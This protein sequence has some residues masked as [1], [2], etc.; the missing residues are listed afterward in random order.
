MR[1]FF[2]NII[3]G[4]LTF[5]LAILLIPGVKI[6]DGLKEKIKVILSAGIVLGLINQFIKPLLNLLVFPLKFLTFGFF[7]LI[8]N[9]LSIWFIDI[10]FPRLIIKGFWPLFWTGALELVLNFFV[11]K[12][13]RNNS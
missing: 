11:A 12:V 3:I 2:F 5:S 1:K 4:L 6:E 7:G 13:I 9:I 10:L 8:V